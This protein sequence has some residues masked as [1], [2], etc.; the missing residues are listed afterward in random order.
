MANI[1]GV[2]EKTPAEK[3]LSMSN[4]GTDLFLE[5]LIS[6][7]RSFEQTGSQKSLIA[8]LEEQKEINDIAPGTAG[9]DIDEMPWNGSSFDEDIRFLLQT[10]EKAKD[11]D[12]WKECGLDLDETVVIPS[13][14]MFADMLKEFRSLYVPDLKE[15]EQEW[16]ITA[17]PITSRSSAD[18]YFGEKTVRIPGEL[19]VHYFLGVPYEMFWLAREDRKIWPW[20]LDDEKRKNRLT[21]TEQ[22]IVMNAVNEHF[23]NAKER[24]FFL[25]RELENR[26]FE[27][28]DMINKG[29]VSRKQAASVLKKEFPELTDEFCRDMITDSLA[30]VRWY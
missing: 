7:S 29:Q 20:K 27:L 30:G 4:R 3:L 21:E 6:A 28:V 25:T 19:M 16:R 1:I 9:F 24:V 13:F 22:K 23:R 11:P 8:F 17:V 10:V 26:A 12:L 15:E 14:D 18:V 2:N 5:L